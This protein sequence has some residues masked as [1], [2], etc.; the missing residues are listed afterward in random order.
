MPVDV[1]APVP[2]RVLGHVHHVV[3]DK[4]AKVPVL[5]QLPWS[6]NHHCSLAVPR[7]GAHRAERGP[8]PSAECV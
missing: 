8:G 4:P 7:S 3:Q 5:P 2:R 1:Q 6:R